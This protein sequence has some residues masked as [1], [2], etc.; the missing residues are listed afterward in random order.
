MAVRGIHPS[1]IILPGKL[2]PLME[3]AKARFSTPPSRNTLYKWCENGDLP[4]K[5]IGG[6]WYVDLGAE[7]SDTGNELANSVLGES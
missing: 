4:A 2:M 6:G 3:Y 7:I 5:K 1:Q